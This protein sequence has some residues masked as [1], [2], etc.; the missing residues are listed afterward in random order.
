MKRLLFIG[1]V[2]AASLPLGAAASPPHV[3]NYPFAFVLLDKVG[4]DGPVEQQPG[5]TNDTGCAWTED[6]HEGYAGTGV[7]DPGAVAVAD[8]CLIADLASTSHLYIINVTSS[9]PALVVSI[10]VGA[11]SSTAIPVP[12]GRNYIYRA[13]VVPSGYTGPDT[14][15]GG[16]GQEQAVE[17]RVESRA[18]KRVKGTYADA[19]LD[20]NNSLSRAEFCP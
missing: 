15:S 18:S 4:F 13:C 11:L 12:D 9:S 17:W 10:T 1:C 2:L 16:I 20:I 19:A 14:I 8:D 7:L 5:V 3:A 6:S